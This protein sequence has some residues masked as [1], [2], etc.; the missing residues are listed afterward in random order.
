MRCHRRGRVTQGAPATP[1]CPGGCS[2]VGPLAA[3]LLLHDGPR[4]GRRS[5]WQSTPRRLQRNCT[6][7]SDGL[8]GKVAGLRSRAEAGQR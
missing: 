7:H 4:R 8:L 3:L 1:M 5:A 2:A 6:G